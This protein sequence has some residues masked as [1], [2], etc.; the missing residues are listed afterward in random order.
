MLHFRH[1]GSLVLAFR[2]EL[3]RRPP[4]GRRIA[5]VELDD[6]FVR[7]GPMTVIEPADVRSPNQ[8]VGGLRSVFGW[9]GE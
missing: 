1:N 8:G 2:L 4:M 9:H 3:K 6:D 5:V 7:R